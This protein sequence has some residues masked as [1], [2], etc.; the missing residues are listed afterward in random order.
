MDGKLREA[1]GIE[2]ERSR[3]VKSERD[4]VTERLLLWRGRRRER[5]GRFE[6]KR[7]LECSHC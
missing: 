7:S 1:E 2:K 4:R 3:M 5:E 6:E